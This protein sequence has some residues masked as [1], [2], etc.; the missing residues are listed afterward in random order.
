MSQL[1]F[2][3]LNSA[4]SQFEAEQLHATEERLAT[5]QSTISAE[6]AN[7]TTYEEKKRNI[8]DELQQEEQA[9]TEQKEELK[10]LQE[11]LDEKTKVV[12]QAKKKAGKAAKALDQVLKDIAVKVGLSLAL[13]RRSAQLLRRMTILRNLASNVRRCIDGVDWKKSNSLCLQVIYATSQWRRSVILYLPSV[14]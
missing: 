12:E 9:I 6:D 11:D 2:L 8:Q 7:L 4:R 10:A 1:K 3:V 5:L 13:A 14:M